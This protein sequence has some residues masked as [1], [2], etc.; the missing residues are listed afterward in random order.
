MDTK[1]IG[2]P[3]E[4]EFGQTPRTMKETQI[5]HSTE[6]TMKVEEYLAYIKEYKS[7]QRPPPPEFNGFP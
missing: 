2:T 5:G 6:M 3:S 1:S 7:G 4:Q